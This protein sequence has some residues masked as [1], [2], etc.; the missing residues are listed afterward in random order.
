MLDQVEVTHTHLT[1]VTRVVFVEI[2]AVV[3]LTTAV[4]ATA[5]MLAVF[6]DTTVTA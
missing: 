2:D 1:E 4:T 3:V 5:R 6:A